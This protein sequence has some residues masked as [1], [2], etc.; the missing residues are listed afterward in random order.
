[1]EVSLSLQGNEENYLEDKLIL[2]SKGKIRKE[3][4]AFK[5]HYHIKPYGSSTGFKITLPFMKWCDIRVGSG[6]SII[7]N[8]GGTFGSKIS[9]IVREQTPKGDIIWREEK[10][11]FTSSSLLGSENV[12]KRFGPYACECILY[13]EIT[14]RG[15]QDSIRSI[16]TSDSKIFVTN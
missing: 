5:D 14:K 11:E 3:E 1:M 10:S 13:L 12:I 6:S 4:S 9:G 7:L 2:E 16:F 8:P 15:L